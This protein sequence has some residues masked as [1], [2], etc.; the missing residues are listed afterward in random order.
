MTDIYEA[1]ARAIVDAQFDLD[2][3]YMSLTEL[4]AAALRE[5]GEEIERLRD[6]LCVQ[7]EAHRLLCKAAGLDEQA[8]LDGTAQA[9]AALC[10]NDIE[11]RG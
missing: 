11:S 6:A 3:P 8:H 1:R 5:R 10:P 2:A 7:I 4:I 9:R